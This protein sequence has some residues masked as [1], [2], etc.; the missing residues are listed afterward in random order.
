MPVLLT[1]QGSG[2]AEKLQWKML[3]TTAQINN[4]FFSHVF[5]FRKTT[6]VF[7]KLELRMN[8]IF[9]LDL[10]IVGYEDG[11]SWSPKKYPD[12]PIQ[13]TY[14]IELP[15]NGKTIKTVEIR[16]HD[17]GGPINTAAVDIWGGRVKKPKNGN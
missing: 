15:V 2:K 4:D 6:D 14:T 8:G 11:T 9:R 1:A 10:I 16:Y 3:G 7:S 13:T 12:I 5:H 17:V